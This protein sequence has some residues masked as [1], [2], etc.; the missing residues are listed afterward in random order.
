MASVLGAPGDVSIRVPEACSW[1]TKAEFLLI[2]ASSN[3]GDDVVERSRADTEAVLS[4]V[5]EKNSEI[6]ARYEVRAL[7]RRSETEA[8]AGNLT[9]YSRWADEAI[10]IAK[11]HDLPQLESDAKRAKHMMVASEES[12]RHLEDV[13]RTYDEIDNH[14]EYLQTL[15]RL[16]IL[17]TNRGEAKAAAEFLTELLEE[18]AESP[19]LVLRNQTI[20]ECLLYIMIDDALIVDSGP[21]DGGVGAHDGITT[22]IQK[23]L[24]DKFDA[25]ADSSVNTYELVEQV[26]S[27]L[28]NIGQQANLDSVVEGAK[29]TIRVLKSSRNRVDDPEQSNM[30]FSHQASGSSGWKEGQRLNNIQNSIYLANSGQ[31]QKAGDLLSA[32]PEKHVVNEMAYLE[33][34]LKG[35]LEFKLGNREQ[36]KMAYE[37]LLEE[38]ANSWEMARLSGIPVDERAMTLAYE[39]NRD[40]ESLEWAKQ[41]IEIANELGHDQKA[42]RLKRF[43]TERISYE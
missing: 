40:E 17:H 9:E 30:S 4:I 13:V 5:R 8:F 23:V 34:A 37:Y 25:T 26:G 24:A 42:D 28:I 38:R 19:G 33:S 2:R 1:Q 27:E 15:G 6:A 22:E 21:V 32:E 12:V 3:E 35:H 36:A 11:E 7:I 43:R 29:A 31:Y 16:V 20:G 18:T 41:S 14:H 39:L 10:T